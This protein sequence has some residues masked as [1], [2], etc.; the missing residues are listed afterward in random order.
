MFRVVATERPLA[1]KPCRRSSGGPAVHALIEL[2]A[3]LIAALA[4]AAFAQ[5]G[6]ELQP[7]DKPQEDREVR[8]TDQRAAASKTDAA[9]LR[10]HQDC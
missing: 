7:L 8:R 9:F 4:A 5:F 1:D 10:T 3:T 6:I 2:F